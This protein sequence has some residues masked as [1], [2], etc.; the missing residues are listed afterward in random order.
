LTAFSVSSEGDFLVAGTYYGM[1]SKLSLSDGKISNYQSR[2]GRVDDLEPLIETELIA[3]TTNDGV[4]HLYNQSIGNDSQSIHTH[5]LLAARLAQSGNGKILVFGSGDGSVSAIKINDLQRPSILWHTEQKPV[6]S[7]CFIGHR[8]KLLAAYENGELRLWNTD[9]GTFQ[10]LI[11]G[12]KGNQRLVD[13]HPG[14]EVFVTGAMSSLE[15]WD[16]KSLQPIHQLNGSTK[17]VS[18]LRFSPSGQY[19]AVAFRSGRICVYNT[20]SWLMPLLE[21]EFG[22]ATIAAV[23]FMDDEATLAIALNSG[24]VELLDIRKL[25]TVD[26][27]E[28]NFEP[29]ALKYCASTKELA[30][31]TSTGQVVFWK[32]TIAGPMTVVNGH[33]GRIQAMAIVLPPTNQMSSTPSSSTLISAGRDKTIRLWDIESREFVTALDGHFRQVFSVSVSA[34]SKTVASGSLEGDIRIWRSQ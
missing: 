17:G 25:K 32:P 14:R 31:G 20:N 29:S 1:I 19:L 23:E 16:V 22:D 2:W 11:A 21:L 5:G 30:I 27:L 12:Q 3:V 24:K 7:I 18:A 8:E 6:R 4:M 10:S 26:T 28:L 13:V 15:V 33:S 9:D 34:D